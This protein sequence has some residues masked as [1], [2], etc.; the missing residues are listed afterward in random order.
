M[1]GLE[2]A[3]LI[4]QD[5]VSLLKRHRQEIQRLLGLPVLGV[6]V[7]IALLSGLHLSP[8]AWLISVVFC[9]KMAVILHRIL[10]S[11]DIEQNVWRT[12]QNEDIA[13]AK[14]FIMIALASWTAGLLL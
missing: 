1:K 8:I 7:F 6:M 2:N 10:A 13:Y 4:I 12:V 11:A 14:K 3:W 5:T 9:V